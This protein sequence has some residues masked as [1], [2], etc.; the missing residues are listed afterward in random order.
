MSKEKKEY[1]KDDDTTHNKVN[2]AMAAYHTTGTG[3]LISL[4]GLDNKKTYQNISGNNDLI[5]IIRQGV[6]MK[7]LQHIMEVTGM[8][9]TEI[10]A[11]THTSDRT[12]RR[13]TPTQKLSQEL[14][15]RIIELA[16]LYTRGEQVFGS[17]D[18]FKIWMDTP[19]MSLGNKTPKTYLDTSIGINMLMN[20]LGRIEH[21]V[22]A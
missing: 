6:P 17:I 20:E 15:E 3:R 10:A 8:H 21:G 12:L 7:A 13:Y 1:Q 5:D 22:F 19:L 9:L 18:N 2:E 11:I 4:M 14:S 16:K